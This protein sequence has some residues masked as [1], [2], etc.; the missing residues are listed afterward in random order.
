MTRYIAQRLVSMVPV[1]VLVSM[2]VFLLMHL[3]PGDPATIMLGMDADAQTRERF[4]AAMGFDQP[5]YVQYASWAA[6]ALQGDLGRSVRQSNEL[7]T[8]AVL[9]RLP[10]TAELSLLATILSLLIAI[11]AGVIA[12]ARRGSAA[13]IA[14]TIL[15]LLGLSLP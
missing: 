15:A 12:G 4:R 3:L 1:V 14:S 9:Q 6:H 2:G 11:P 8:A 5:I 7:V 10:V 13:G